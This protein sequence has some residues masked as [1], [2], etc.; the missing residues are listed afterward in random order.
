MK[1]KQ[2]ILKCIYKFA[3]VNK[4]TITNVV[5]TNRTLNLQSATDGYLSVPRSRKTLFDGL[6]STSE[7]NLLSSLP[8]QIRSLPS[9]EV[10]KRST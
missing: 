1:D 4:E 2:D 8:R 9:F 6:F 7:P 3:S 5:I 10:L